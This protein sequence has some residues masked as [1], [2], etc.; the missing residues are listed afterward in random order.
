MKNQYGFAVKPPPHYRI[1]NPNQNSI[2]N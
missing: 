1:L 2:D